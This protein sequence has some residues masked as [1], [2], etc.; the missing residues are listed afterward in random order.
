V[1]SD[2]GGFPE[3]VQ[4]TKT[5]IVTWTNNADSLAW[6]ILEVLKNPDYKQWLVDNAYQD[7]ERRFSWPKLAKQTE[8]VYQRVVQE[9]SHLVW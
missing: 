2:T 1:V 8:G 3:V 4:H 5:G 9:R 7:L 6:G